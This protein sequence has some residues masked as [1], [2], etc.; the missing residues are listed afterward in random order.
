MLSELKIL[1]EELGSYSNDHVAN[2][3][4]YQATVE[5]DKKYRKKF[6]DLFQ[7]WKQ[8]CIAQEMNLEEVNEI[9]A[10]LRGEIKRQRELGISPNVK[11]LT[12]LSFVWSFFHRL[13]ELKY[14]I[15]KHTVD[16]SEC[17]CQLK[18]DWSTNNPNKEF[19]GQIG[20]VCYYHREDQHPLYQC[21]KCGH[22][23]V[24]A[25]LYYDGPIGKVVASWNP[26]DWPLVEDS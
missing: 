14:E 24:F 7:A 16:K 8:R 4:D 21:K 17:Y 10:H 18:A 22:K 15:T 1:L 5:R 20:I 23:W 13:N 3:V 11:K 9:E 19:L 12:S 6:D 26:K 2:H 25:E